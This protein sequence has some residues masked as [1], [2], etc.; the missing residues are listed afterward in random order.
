MKKT[1]SLAVLA[2]ALACGS[3]S[4]QQVNV[5]IGVLTDMSSLYA[6]NTGIGSVVAAKMAAAAY[7]LPINGSTSSMWT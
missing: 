5:K 6:D 3:A 2:I 1:M 7:R 4:A